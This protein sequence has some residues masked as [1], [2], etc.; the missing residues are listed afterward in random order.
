MEINLSME[1]ENGNLHVS[2]NR[3]SGVNEIDFVWIEH[4][5][6][7]FHEKDSNIF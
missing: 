3:Y 6:I 4:L 1:L 5:L 2:S 7:V